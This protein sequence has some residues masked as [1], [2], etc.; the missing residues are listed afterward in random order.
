MLPVRSPSDIALS[1]PDLAAPESFLF[2]FLGV[3]AL[4]SYICYQRPLRRTLT[5]FRQLPTGP[6]SITTLSSTSARLNQL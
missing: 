5:S 3:V 1:N 4:I 2:D 6:G